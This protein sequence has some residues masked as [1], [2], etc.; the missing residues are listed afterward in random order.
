M[1]PGDRCYGAGGEESG[2]RASGSG[3]AGRQWP[4]WGT[5]IGAGIGTRIAE[6]YL[7]RDEAV[8]VCSV[9]SCSCGR[10]IRGTMIIG[11]PNAATAD[12]KQRIIV[13]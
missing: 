6:A 7:D 3:R 13:R 12:T 8:L 1:R 4:H 9:W 2:G 10:V 11:I 5:G